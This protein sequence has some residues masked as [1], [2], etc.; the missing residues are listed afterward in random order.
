MSIY[1]SGWSLFANEMRHY[2]RKIQKYSE[3]SFLR[4]K[5]KLELVYFRKALLWQDTRIFNGLNNTL[6]FKKISATHLCIFLV[7]YIFSRLKID[8]KQIRFAAATLR[9]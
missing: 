7:H 3:Y 8:T 4:V 2:F 1:G 9:V 5:F 6:I